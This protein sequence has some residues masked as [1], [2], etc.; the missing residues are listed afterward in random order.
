MPYYFRRR[1]NRWTRWR[2]YY[3][4]WRPR[5]HLRRRRRW[6]KRK[7]VRRKLSKIIVKQYQPETIRKSCIRGIQA[8]L[9]TNQKR[10][11][12]NFRDYENSF[13][14]HNEPGGGGY[15]IT[16]YNLD[17]F[18]EQHLKVRNWWTNTNRNLPLCKY[19]GC[20]LKLYKSENVDYVCSYFTCYPMVN[21]LALTNS[22]CPGIQLMN[23]DSIIVP[24]KRTEPKGKPYKRV[25]IRPP[26]QLESKWYFTQDLAKTGLLLFTCTACSLDHY[27][28]SSSAESNNVG[29]K[30]LN[31]KYINRHNFGSTTTYGWIPYIEGTNQKTFWAHK[32]AAPA[33]EQIQNLFFKDLIYL[34]N[35]ST[36]QIGDTVETKWIS[37]S[38][39]TY[40]DSYKNWGNIFWQ[41]YINGEALLLV[42]TESNWETIKTWAK[43]KTKKLTTDTKFTKLTEPLWLY[44]RYTPET[45][46]GIGNQSYI[47]PNVRDDKNWDPP[48]SENLKHG[49][50]PLWIMFF[51]WLDWLRK[52]KFVIHMDE[53]YTIVFKCPFITPKLDYYV[54][55]DDSMFENRSP[56][57]PEPGDIVPSDTNNWNPH[58][59][60]QQVTLENICA[61]GPGTA[62]FP[63]GTKSVEAKC[64]YKFY[65]KFGGCP[66]KM[67]QV[68]NPT[69]QGKWPIPGTEQ[70]IYSL[71]S[72]SLPP[73]SLLYRF[74]TRQ[75]LITKRAAKRIKTDWGIEKALFSPSGE[76]TT[77][78]QPAE[79]PETSS[80]EAE[81]SENEEETLLHQL[82]R[83]RRKRKH[84]QLK[85][86]SL[87]HQS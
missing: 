63:H 29:F 10:L 13:I 61:C 8:L 50:F 38:N 67:E 33:T 55:M 17:A 9:I 12:N 39:N 62:K 41:G 11:A 2:R 59:R 84:L 34:G 19:L 48:T 57:Q 18:Y 49:N 36:Y 53:F 45:D 43:D 54:P 75:D 64:Y 83:Y 78:I 69:T 22:C 16:K 87:M 23:P 28:I 32:N 27:F 6:R 21:T 70:Q 31:T 44:C 51:G 4:N 80:E 14:H 68:E 15:S 47:L 82:Q 3:S 7:R 72:P 85:L 71:Q 25:K 30:S 58:V 46:T 40:F 81:D 86:L 73:E 24:S 1:R 35:A 79:S 76:W 5:T 52:G 37:S 74:D 77:P 42:C 20:S 26:A 56:Y 65:F 66:P 60:F